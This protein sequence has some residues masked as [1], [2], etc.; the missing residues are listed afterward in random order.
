MENEEL[1]LEQCRPVVRRVLA[2]R[3]WELVEDEDDFAEEVFEE[4]QRRLEL[5]TP[6]ARSRKPLVKVIEDATV[7]RYNHIWYAACGADGTIRQRQAFTELHN[8]L[9][10]IALYRANHDQE[11]AR[12]GTQEALI[13]VWKNLSKV[14]DPGAFARYAGM[15]LGREVGR[16]LKKALQRRE[17]EMPE[18][19]LQHG[20]ESDGEESDISRHSS[21]GGHV[22]QELTVL[23]TFP[24]EQREEVEDVIKHCL[25]RSKQRQEVIITRFLDDKTVNETAEELGKKPSDVHLLTHRAKEGLRKCKK[26]LELMEAWLL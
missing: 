10:P 8:Y 12:E 24:E 23:S 26:F 19:E 22:R 1:T 5:M 2:E 7:N 6:V 3:G 18:S 11:I 21:K 25:K 9:L 14:R 17:K 4:F 20:D 16:K 15:I 13:I